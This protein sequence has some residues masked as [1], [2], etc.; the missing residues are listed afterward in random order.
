MMINPKDNKRAEETI[1]FGTGLILS[2]VIMECFFVRM[3]QN[4][5]TTMNVC[6]MKMD[7]KER[8]S[9]LFSGKYR[10]P[11]TKGMVPIKRANRMEIMTTQNEVL[12]VVSWFI[13]FY[14]IVLKSA[15]T[16]VFFFRRE[17]S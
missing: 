2:D 12:A 11:T 17:R 3:Y 4:K 6:P 1:F 15:G 8:G 10:L 9:V 13:F 7:M 5:G 16:Y 14:I